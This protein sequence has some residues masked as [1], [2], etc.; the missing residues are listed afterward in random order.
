MFQE[1]TYC[2]LFTYLYYTQPQNDLNKGENIL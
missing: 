1:L 2:D